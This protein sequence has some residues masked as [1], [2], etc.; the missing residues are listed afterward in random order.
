MVVP[1]EETSAMH[2]EGLGH[3]LHLADARGVGAAAPGFEVLLGSGLGSL[4]PAKAGRGSGLIV[5]PKW[6]IK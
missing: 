6:P 1:V 4:V 3:D 5:P 2:P